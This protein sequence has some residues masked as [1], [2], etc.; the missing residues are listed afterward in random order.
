MLIILNDF[1]ISCVRE[2]KGKDFFGLYTRFI[3]FWSRTRRRREVKTYLPG[4]ESQ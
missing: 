2:P 1:M 4:I 3:G